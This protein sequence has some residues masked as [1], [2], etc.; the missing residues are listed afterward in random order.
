MELDKF[1]F[2]GT[3]YFYVD[4]PSWQYTRRVKTSYHCLILVVEGTLYMEIDGMRYSASKNEFLFMRDVN[5]SRGYCGSNKPT[6]F[7]Q[8]IFRAEKVP[9]FPTRFKVDQS[10]D[11]SALYGLLNSMSRNKDYDQK[12]KNAFLYVL[13]YQVYY[14]LTRESAEQL[15][16]SISIADKMK[17]YIN[18]SLGR[19]LTVQD[20]AYHFGFSVGHTQRLFLKEFHITIKTYINEM[21]IKEIKTHL[22]S[23]NISLTALAEKLD[24]PNTSALHKYFKY[25]T[26]QTINEFREKF[27]D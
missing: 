5:I 2:K 14:Q 20:V 3:N 19:S 23:T 12:A 10:S 16:Q 27:I 7:W 4:S 25:H 17:K 24:F 11:I 8:V 26:G 22:T 9:K 13:L 1:D 6:A 21:K 15:P 18:N